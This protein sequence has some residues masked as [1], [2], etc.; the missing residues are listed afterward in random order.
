V[1]SLSIRSLTWLLVLAGGLVALATGTYG[2]LRIIPVVREVRTAT[3]PLVELSHRLRGYDTW[4]QHGAALAERT[5]GAP[6]PARL[7]SLY[8]WMGRYDQLAGALRIAD[9]PDSVRVLLAAADGA[10]ARFSV[11]GQEI[12]ALLQLGRRADAMARLEI[13]RRLAGEVRAL[14]A[15]SQTRSLDRLVAA[16]RAVEALST[17][18][19]GAFV[20]W[21]LGTALVM[22]VALRFVRRRVQTPLAELQSALG[23]MADGDLGVQLVPRA[24]DEIGGLARQFNQMTAVLRSRAETQGQMAAAGVL[25]GNVAHELNNPLMAI[26]ATAEARLADPGVP[27][28]VRRDLEA[29]LEQVRRAGRLV[30]GIVRFVQAAPASETR[31]DVNDA[32]REAVELMAVQ[33]AADG[34]ECA[35]ELGAGRPAAATGQAL[36]RILV[37][38]LAN[39]HEALGRGGESGARRVTVRTWSDASR[40][41]VEVRDTGPGV[42]DEVRARLFLPFST[43]RPGG[44]VGLGLYTARRIA[45]E[46]GGDITYEPRRDVPGAV[47]VVALPAAPAPAAAAPAAPAPDGAAAAPSHPPRE[48]GLKGRRVLLVDDE[49]MV[50]A[51]LARFLTRRGATVREAGDG[52]EA[53]GVLSAEAPDVIVADLRMPGMDGAAL[54]RAV[55]DRDPALA[56]RMVFLSGDVGQLGGADAGAITPDRVLPK[57]VELAEF[58][59]FLLRHLDI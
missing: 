35:F 59:R 9:V 16:Q 30:G 40:V 7:D 14:A 27:A 20:V 1:K 50:R 33:F 29:V 56:A 8:R 3:A 52:L 2:A 49:P 32:A 37:A 41:F 34:V 43:A 5:V 4:I 18:L 38:L 26:G 58:E 23:R 47:F 25:L 28:P 55:R 6:G 13:C 21:M 39:A 15:E 57:P 10:A 45:R 31:A 24:E 54:F 44:H 19:L 46:A 48:A 17:R 53:L 51:P 36:E 11:T 42:G 22:L 12:G